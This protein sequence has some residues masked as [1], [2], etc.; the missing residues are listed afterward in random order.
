[1]RS[2]DLKSAEEE[3]HTGCF[4]ASIYYNLCALEVS[5]VET[6]IVARSCLPLAMSILDYHF[7]G[8]QV[9]LSATK[10]SKVRF[11]SLCSTHLA[12]SVSAQQVAH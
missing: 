12:S 8:R 10:N 1:M 6:L 5:S 3:V 11:G 9:T 7:L 2:T 4:V